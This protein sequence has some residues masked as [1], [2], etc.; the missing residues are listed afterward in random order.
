MPQ[1]LCNQ[2]SRAFYK[3]DLRQIRLLND[4]W[5]FYRNKTVQSSQPAKDRQAHES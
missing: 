4:C 1:W 3:K 5:F 2:L